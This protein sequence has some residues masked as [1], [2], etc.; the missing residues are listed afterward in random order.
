MVECTLFLGM[1][2]LL[3]WCVVDVDWNAYQ[4]IYN[5]TV[6]LEKLILKPLKQPISLEIN[7]P[8]RKYLNIDTSGYTS[9]IVCSVLQ[10]LKTIN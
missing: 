1:V 9:E 6:V 5:I 3:E 2:V 7:F 8:E 4:K 10:F